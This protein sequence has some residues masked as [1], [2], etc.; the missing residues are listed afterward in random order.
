MAQEGAN[1]RV[2]FYRRPTTLPSSHP[3]SRQATS[4]LARLSLPSRKRSRRVL[5]A[6]CF[7]SSP[8]S[9]GPQGSS[10]E[11]EGSAPSA[12]G[13]KMGSNAVKTAKGGAPAPGAA[14]H[15]VWSEIFDLYF[16]EAGR[17]PRRG[18]AALAEGRAK[19]SEVWRVL[20]DRTHPSLSLAKPR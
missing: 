11:A 5:P 10:G 19:W 4:S 14:P 20:V 18:E 2:Y 7:Y 12:K 17:A 6:R 16:P 3:P 15:F 1:G 13:P 8:N 9:L